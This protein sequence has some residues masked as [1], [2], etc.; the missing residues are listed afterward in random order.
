[1]I[2]VLLVLLPFLG[3]VA[4]ALVSRGG[5]DAC[6]VTAGVATAVALGLLG[7]LAPGVVAGEVVQASV[8]WVPALGLQASFFVDALGLTLAGLILGVG[9]L[10]VVYARYYLAAADPP[11]RF[12]AFLLL[13]QGAMLG[14]ALSS[15]VLLLLVFWELTSLSSF[16]LI[17]YWRHLPEARRGARMALTVTGAGGLSLLAGLLLLGHSAGTYELPVL[18]QRREA[19]Q[20]SPLYLPALL[21]ILGGCFTKSAQFP[22]HFWLPQAMAAPTP[23]SAY[24]HSATMVKA[25][26][27][28]LARLW[29]VLAGT[30]AWFLIVTTTG[31]VTM[32]VGAVSALFEDDLKG[33]LA[34]ST[35][36]QLGLLTMLFGLGTRMG[37]VVGVFH[38]VNHAL[39]KAALFMNA[40]IV[41]HEA[42]TRDVKGLGG[43]GSLMPVAATVA[44][45]ASA[46]MAGVPPLN[47][48]LSKEM[49]L[50]EAAHT[51]LLGQAWLVP[52]VVTVGATLS[53]AYA[54]RYVVRVYFGARRGEALASGQGAGAHHDSCAPPEASR[55]PEAGR[56]GGAA[57]PHDPPLGM[58]APS[59]LLGALALVVGLF[60][61]TLAGPLVRAASAAVIGGAPPGF[62]LALW[63]G[64]TPALGMSVVALVGGAG[65]LA[66]HGGAEKVWRRLGVPDPAGWFEAGLGA[67]VKGSRKLTLAIHDGSLQRGL[68]L[69]VGTAVMVGFVGFGGAKHTAGER[70]PMPVEMLTV[71]AWVLLV[72]ATGA[73][74]VMHRRRY[75]PLL[76]MGVVSM[77]MALAFIFLS[78]PDLALTQVSVDVV[79]I[80]LLLLALNLLPQQSPPETT[81]RRRVRDAVLALLGGVGMGSA[82]WAVMTRERKTLADYY[83]T[84][85][86]PEGGGTNV[87]NVILVD[88]RGFDTFGEIVVLGTAALAIFAL[89]ETANR[90]EAGR[91]L[92][93]W[94][95]GRPLSPERYPLI[96]IAVTRLLLP[97]AIV[98]ALFMFLRGHDHPGGGFVAGLVVAIAVL[99]QYLASGFDWADRRV[100][101]DHH[102]LIGWGVLVA[103]LTGLGALVFGRP[104]LTS[105]FWHP[106]LPFVGE[107]A[108]STAMVFDAGVTLAVVGAVMLAL[109]QLASASK[110][111]KQWAEK[112][113]RGEHG[114]AP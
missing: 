1:M 5:R 13:F 24:L 95:P 109:A 70:P 15:N 27:F 34:R 17:G 78:A 94:K 45:V 19:I 41:D 4:T 32:L 14:V 8:G 48:F 26:I 112:R 12:Y 39:F 53:V 104:F 83:W 76:F 28:L 103:A 67:A 108:L 37:A 2:L 18:L 89:L 50:E 75:L 87:V 97:F 43:L 58:G 82:A 107:I 92:A 102:A 31:L 63:H 35:I 105:A 62:T 40:G 86:K 106:R 65:V 57:A 59:V 74:V 90:G 10:V 38:L 99:M 79:T 98:T 21:L 42:G 52:V 64:F 114:G 51:R 84:H 68:A 72:T 20:G 81:R 55:G 49:M 113:E 100:R 56:G 23:V 88:F 69:L 93:Q 36:S 71:L 77:I 6:A 9:L 54:L 22:F 73:A 30:E 16:L 110:R 61:E 11:G 3:A 25:G 46:A 111:A 44:V 85:A 7:A 101:P 29:P 66:V 91:R 47:G 33:L 60:P 96:L 80:L